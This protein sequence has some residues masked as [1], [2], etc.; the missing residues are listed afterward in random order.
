[1]T[2]AARIAALALA[3][4]ALAA[5]LPGAGSDAREDRDAAYRE[6]EL[7][8]EARRWILEG[9]VDAPDPRA[10]FRGALRGMAE[11]LDPW[12]TLLSPEEVRAMREDASGVYGGVGVL[13]GER[14]GEAVAAAVEEGGPAHRAGMRRGDVLLEAGGAAVRGRDLDRVSLR[15][16]GDPG[17]E[18]AVKVRRPPGGGLLEFR[19]RREPVEVRSVRR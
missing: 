6:A 12:S 18:V 2:R 1:M 5:T 15:L 10:V 11:S 8:A 9:Y 7:L 3:A 14:G 16:R 13:L 19:R 17:T 4:S